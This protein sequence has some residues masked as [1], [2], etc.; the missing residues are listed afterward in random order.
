VIAAAD[1]RNHAD[2]FGWDAHID[3]RRLEDT[4]VHGQ[5]MVT[6]DYRRDGTV[7][8]AYRYVFNRITHPKL[9][10]ATGARNKKSAVV[11][12]LVRLGN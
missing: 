12:W 11:A 7:D 8:R 4:F 1:I 9:Q 2:M 10:E 6:V 5:H 3:N